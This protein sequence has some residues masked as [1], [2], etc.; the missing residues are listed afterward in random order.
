M[1]RRPMHLS[2]SKTTDNHAW[3]LK[4]QSSVL[5]I[6]RLEKWSK[7]VIQEETYVEHVFAT[8][9]CHRIS[10]SKQETFICSSTVSS[11]GVSRLLI[12]LLRQAEQMLENQPEDVVICKILYIYVL[13]TWPKTNWFYYEQVEKRV[14]QDIW[15]L[16]S[17]EFAWRIGMLAV[18]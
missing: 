1:T 15:I 12:W 3:H 7:V 10:A 17:Q 13:C 11:H 2:C 6:Y 5:E 9:I 16:G 18:G 4:M 8:R 14:I